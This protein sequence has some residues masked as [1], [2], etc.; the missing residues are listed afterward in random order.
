MD[1]SPSQQKAGIKLSLPESCIQ[2]LEYISS[3]VLQ[4]YA[5]IEDG[6]NRNTSLVFGVHLIFKYFIYF[7]NQ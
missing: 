3:L 5:V 2:I 1:C 7:L 6:H 4:S